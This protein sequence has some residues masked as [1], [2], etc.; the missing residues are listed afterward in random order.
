MN[1]N[2][3]VNRRAGKIVKRRLSRPAE[4]QRIYLQDCTNGLIQLVSG[5]AR[6]GQDAGGAED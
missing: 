5:D 2:A 4:G 1:G 6:L 3:E